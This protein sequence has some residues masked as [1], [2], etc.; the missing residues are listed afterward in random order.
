MRKRQTKTEKV[1]YDRDA[2]TSAVK[3]FVDAYNNYIGCEWK[4]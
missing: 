4:C 1:D 3:N 2:I